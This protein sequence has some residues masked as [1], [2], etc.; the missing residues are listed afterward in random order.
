[1]LTA[2]LGREAATAK[3]FPV[4]LEEQWSHTTSFMRFVTEA[5]SLP[6]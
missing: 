2:E 5:L 6:F 4:R 3:D 1:M